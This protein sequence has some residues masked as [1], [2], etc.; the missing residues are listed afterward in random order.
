MQ[1]SASGLA[2]HWMEC[3]TRDPCIISNTPLGIHVYFLY[4]LAILAAISHYYCKTDMSARG[5]VSQWF[6]VR[7][8]NQARHFVIFLWVSNIFD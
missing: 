1:Y 8:N 6:G 4:S 7:R 3:I 5:V 2:L